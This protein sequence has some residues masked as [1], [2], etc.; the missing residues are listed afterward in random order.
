M[1]SSPPMRDADQL[2][3]QAFERARYFL[4]MWGR[5][6]V[7]RTSGGLGYGQSVLVTLQR[8][9]R[10]AEHY[11]AP[12]NEATCS[13]IDDVVRRLGREWHQIAVMHFGYGYTCNFIARSRK[14]AWATVDRRLE[15]VIRAVAYP[16]R[17][18]RSDADRVM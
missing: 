4:E 11:Q 6:I 14:M 8:A 1:N 18:P 13:Q 12:I 15:E 7:Q 17:V 5:W 2:H 10:S 3:Q 16:N 9:A